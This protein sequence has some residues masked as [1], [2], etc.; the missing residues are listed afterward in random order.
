MRVSVLL[1]MFLRQGLL[2][3]CFPRA[4]VIALILIESMKKYGAVYSLY[5]SVEFIEEW[6]KNQ[7]TEKSK[8]L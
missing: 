8:K 4:L 1:L 3:K 7:G 2:L 6:S 5:T